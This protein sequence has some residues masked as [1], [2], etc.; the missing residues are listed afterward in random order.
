MQGALE[1]KKNKKKRKKGLET[2][3]FALKDTSNVVGKSSLDRARMRLLMNN[4]L[5]DYARMMALSRE[6]VDLIEKQFYL[7]RHRV[8]DT[9]NRLHLA[10]EVS[11]KQC[12][13]RII[14]FTDSFYDYLNL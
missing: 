9:L 14:K 4:N 12:L 13:V 8:L 2:D 7:V 11:R 3:D 5:M 1:K 6:E 10:K